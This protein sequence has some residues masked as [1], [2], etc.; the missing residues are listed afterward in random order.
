MS[1]SLSDRSFSNQFMRLAHFRFDAAN[2][3]DRFASDYI[4]TMG[5]ASRMTTEKCSVML[6]TRGLSCRGCILKVRN[7]FHTIV[8]HIRKGGY[9]ADPDFEAPIIRM[10]RNHITTD[11]LG[12]F[13]Q[14]K[15]EKRAKPE[16][17]KRTTLPVMDKPCST[18]KRSKLDRAF[19]KNE[20]RQSLAGTSNILDTASTPTQMLDGRIDVAAPEFN[21]QSIRP[22]KVFFVGT[23]RKCGTRRSKIVSNDDCYICHAREKFDRK[24]TNPPRRSV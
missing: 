9:L 11:K 17:Q 24:Y 14:E 15:A 4:C 23:C 8:D 12:A 1:E 3:Q 6:A 20:V 2:F 21:P 19:S 10:I 16:P 7:N 18:S 22:P 5:G 13:C